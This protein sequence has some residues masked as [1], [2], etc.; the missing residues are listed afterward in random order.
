[1]RVDRI[2]VTAAVLACLTSA[3]SENHSAHSQLANGGDPERG[4]QVIADVGCGACHT[5]PGVRAANGLVGPPLMW[6]SRRAYIAGEL[7]NT[8]ENLVKW[9]R[10]PRSVEAH[11]A[12]PAVGLNEQQAKDVAAYLYTLN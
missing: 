3:C 2:L 11:T 9:V 7:P 8:P 4:R 5:I 1:M 10:F 6:W 12:M